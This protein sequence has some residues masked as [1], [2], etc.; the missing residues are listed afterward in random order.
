MRKVSSGLSI[1]T[2]CSTQWFCCGQRRLWSD[3]AD[4]QADL[5]VRCSHI[6]EDMFSH[7]SA[8][9]LL[10]HRQKVRRFIFSFYSG[11]TSLSPVFQSYRDGV[12]IWQGTQCSTFRVM[13]PEIS[14]PG[15]IM[16]NSI[17]SH[18]IDTRPISSAFSMLS[19]SKRA[20]STIFKVFGMTRPGIEPTT[21]R[22]QSEC[23]SIWATAPVSLKV[24][25][26]LIVDGVYYM[27][28]TEPIK[29]LGAQGKSPL[30]S[31]QFDQSSLCTQ[32]VAKDPRFVQSPRLICVCARCTCQ[33]VDYCH[34]ATHI[35]S[36]ATRNTVMGPFMPHPFPITIVNYFE[37]FYYDKY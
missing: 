12:S 10:M 18:Y 3:C 27:R 29:W 37:G 8:L 11:W 25:G 21:S 34:A 4:A 7:S 13:F 26:L 19:A 31:A 28:M 22:T 6:P 23:S 20:A 14:R 9:T 24:F 15:N 36:V 30:V 5:C 16:W 33:F 2:F 17:Q 35:C 1:E 32:W